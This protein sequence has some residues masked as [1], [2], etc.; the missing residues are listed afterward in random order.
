MG[1]E[2]RKAANHST[3]QG[4]VSYNAQM[5]LVQIV[6]TAKVEKFC[7][8]RMKQKQDVR[9]EMIDLSLF[10][11]SQSKSNKGALPET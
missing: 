8:K 5:Y 3:T 2:A 1:L 6:N 9:V 10:T 7:S 4:I 11:H